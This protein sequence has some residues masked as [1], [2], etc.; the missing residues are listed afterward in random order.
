MSSLITRVAVALFATLSLS[1]VA[2]GAPAYVNRAVV[3]AIVYDELMDYRAPTHQQTELDAYH[4]V[5]F[6]TWF[7]SRCSVF[8]AALERKVLA[9]YG[10]LREL[11]EKPART[12]EQ[13][14]QVDAVRDGI[15]DAKAFL[16]EHG[17]NQPD[18]RRAKAT[19]RHVF[20]AGENAQNAQDKAKEKD[21]A[22]RPASSQ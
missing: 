7:H 17:C 10:Q 6:A 15:K 9:A 8:D 12:A 21:K 20:K 4:V 16:S 1:A 11:S 22:V 3:D 19:L 13:Q 2:A 5:G 18:A 14:G